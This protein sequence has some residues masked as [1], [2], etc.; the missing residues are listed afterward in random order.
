MSPSPLL[1]KTASPSRL[2]RNVVSG[3]LSWGGVSLTCWM[4]S[5]WVHALVRVGQQ[6]LVF[7]QGVLLSVVSWS[8]VSEA[9]RCDTSLVYLVRVPVLSWNAVRPAASAATMSS[10]ASVVKAILHDAI[11]IH[12]EVSVLIH[13]VIIL[14]TIE[15]VIIVVLF[16]GIERLLLLPR[17]LSHWCLGLLGLHELFLGGLLSEAIGVL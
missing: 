14:V 12:A 5:S 6:V 16:E 4:A 15:H 8:L 10:I 9:V 3:L 1:L 11:L 2:A 17:L 7:V 13:T